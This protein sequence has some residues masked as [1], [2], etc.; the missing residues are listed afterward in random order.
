M[1]V[2][3]TFSRPRDNGKMKHIT[4]VCY[5]KNKKGYV[6][7]ES[8]KVS[9]KVNWVLINFTNASIFSGPFFFGREIKEDIKEQ[10]GQYIRNLY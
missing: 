7:R 1:R 5:E 9:M 4:F 6:D 8:A 2:K 10:S 3:E